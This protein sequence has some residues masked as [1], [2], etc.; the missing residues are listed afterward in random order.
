MV[1]TS[2]IGE[3]LRIDFQIIQKISKFKVFILNSLFMLVR[4]YLKMAYHLL[5]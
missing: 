5:A 3:F 2:P 4:E 1:Q